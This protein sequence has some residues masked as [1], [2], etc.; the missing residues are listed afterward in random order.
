MCNV[1][2]PSI[3]D[4]TL[5][6]GSDSAPTRIHG[7]DLARA[8]AV[9]GMVAVNYRVV[10]VAG[11]HP[12]SWVL[13]LVGLL[14]GRAAATFVVLAGIGISLL[15]KR[16]L[17]ADPSSLVACGRE[18]LLRRAVFLFVV[19]LLYTPF[20]PPDILHF[21]GVY[22]AAGA[23][24][25]RA[26]DKTLLWLAGAANAVFF[27]L[28]LVLDYE[29]GWN[30]ASLEYMGFWTPNGF[31]R[32]L[33]FN[34]FHPFFPWVAF[35]FIGMW[36]GRRSLDEATVARRLVIGGVALVVVIE[37]LSAG[38]IRSLG[39]V[40][41][42]T[43]AEE[44]LA[45]LGTEMMPPMPQ[46]ILA[47][48]GTAFATVGCCVLLVQRLGT[49]MLGPLLATGRLALTLYVAHVVL[50]LGLLESIGTLEDRTPGFASAY[51]GGFCMLAVAFA[52]LWTRRF[53]AGPLERLLRTVIRRR[54]QG[55]S[56]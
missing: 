30:W 18:L 55:G 16:A 1:A 27:I 38:V 11:E 41:G 21:Y 10:M 49:G 14:E 32:N 22:I 9:F 19:G 3:D 42:S 7:L 48:T 39:L 54:P 43:E 33:F 51:A 25:L 29:S 44:L 24:L 26:K 6:G 4:G 12:G 52:E 34:G 37:S 17:T 47:G 5:H 50:G 28:L 53:G 13:W 40:R 8:V 46:Y 45:L 36:L 35:L 15:A 2:A 20:W 31:L 56:Y 23:M